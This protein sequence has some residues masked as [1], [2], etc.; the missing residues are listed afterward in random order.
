MTNWDDV[1]R[2]PRRRAGDLPARDI[3]T[4]PGV[5]VWFHDGVAAYLGVARGGTGLRGRLRAHLARTRDLSRSTLRASVAVAELGV[6]RRTARS[7]PPEL[8]ADQVSVV[9]AWLADCELAWLTTDTAADADAL[10][11][12]LL[13]NRKPSLNRR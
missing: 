6:D 3:P 10:E 8:T 7:R 4:R 11:R 12:A 1:H 2:L 13:A 5:Y 9:N